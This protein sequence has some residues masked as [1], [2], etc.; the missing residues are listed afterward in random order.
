MNAVRTLAEVVS[1]TRNWREV[2][3]LGLVD[4]LLSYCGDHGCRL[5]WQGG[6]IATDQG[7]RVAAAFP[8]SVL[9][10]AIARVAAL[11]NRHRPRSVSAY[12]GQGDFVIDAPA[13]A[14]F[15]ADFVNTPDEQRLELTSVVAPPTK[16]AP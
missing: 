7:E 10:A 1:P 11:C 14:H 12:G 3:V 4:E 16:A 9:R 13:R 8:P 2:G 5:T 6:Q 15:R